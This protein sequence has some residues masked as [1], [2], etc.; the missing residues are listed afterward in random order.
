MGEQN[1]RTYAQAIRDF[2]HA[3]EKAALQEIMGRLRGQPTELLSY[4]DVREKLHA[5]PRPTRELR[6]ISLDAIVGSVGRYS[7]FTRSFLPREAGDEQRWARVKAMTESM[8]GLPPIEVYQVGD[9]YFVSDGHHR[10]SVSR[11][12]GAASIE[13]YVTQVQVRVPLSP[14]DDPRTVIIKGEYTDFLE[15]TELDELRP[16]AEILLTEPGKYD[17]LLEHI[18]VHRYYMGVEQ[19]RSV[20]YSEA[21]VHWY[22]EVYT[23]VVEAIR[24]QGILRD[25]PGRTEADL[26]LWVL[27]HREELREWLGWEVG[28]EQAVADLAARHSASPKRIAGRVG[29]RLREAVVPDELEGGPPAG[30]WR[31]RV[32]D[33]R[34]DESLF[35]DILVAIR[36][37]E[38][39]WRAVDQALMVAE[40]EEG[41]LLGLHVLPSNSAADLERGEAIAARFRQRCEER[42]ITG[43]LVTELGEVA[44]AI[45]DRARWADLVVLA[46]D[47]PPGGTTLQRLSSGLR[48]LVRTSPRPLL[49][50]PEESTDLG[51]PLLAYDSSPKAR[52]ALYIG[53]YMASAWNR[54]LAVLS[55]EERH[56]DAARAQEEARAYL[57][58]R[59]VECIYYRRE[60]SV[61][62]QLFDLAA[63]EGSDLLLLGGYGHSPVVEAF[64]GS[65]VDEVLRS[66][67]QPIL[68]CR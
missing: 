51:R 18:D 40:E 45:V 8:E 35:R 57:E 33:R 20:P 56:A 23:P 36:G 27:E 15:R 47:H 55:V 4:E 7:D 67:Q 19:E 61:S 11:E 64:L 52:E 31:R 24:Q 59:D 16:E 44:L 29:D 14:E 68:I 54:P 6:E 17:R 30:D 60:G 26:Y 32:V 42:D 10:V 66:A 1:H 50:V 2:R 13:A 49:F 12:V 63:T 62:D 48:K 21:V 46:L 41:R 3:R 65:S 34:A 43:R 5:R 28:P 25:F 22:D 9:A 53:A 37:D 38:L 58:E 39:G